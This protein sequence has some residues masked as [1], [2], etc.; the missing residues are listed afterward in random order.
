MRC[1]HRRL[2]TPSGIPENV[3][4]LVVPARGMADIMEHIGPFVK[5]N[6]QGIVAMNVLGQ[7]EAGLIIG[8]FRLERVEK[9]IPDDK[10]ASRI[11][12]NIFGIASVMHAVVRRRVEYEFEG[13]YRTD[14]FGMN[15]ELVKKTD[16]TNRHDHGWG[17][18][19]DWHPQPKD[20]AHGATRPGLPERC[21]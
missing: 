1:S 20:E 14:Q 21:G 15:P 17:E 6:P 11:A 4:K 19:D 8:V 7:A 3:P 10:Y 18:A 9:S 12:V 13:A 5:S 2:V 16:R